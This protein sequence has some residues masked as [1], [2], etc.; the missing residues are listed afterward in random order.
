MT[1][2]ELQ[3]TCDWLKYAASEVPWIARHLGKA[4]WFTADDVRPH[5]DMPHNH[6]LIGQLF[7][8]LCADGVIAPVGYERSKRPIA[9]G[10]VVRVWRLV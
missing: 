6:N 4:D 2:L 9:G 10:H 7:K 5:L 1:Q 8:Q 3:P